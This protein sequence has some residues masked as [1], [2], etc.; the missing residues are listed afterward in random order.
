MVSNQKVEETRR[1]YVQGLILPALER[2]LE[3]KLCLG[4]LRLSSRAL[5]VS[6]KEWL[7]SQA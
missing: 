7:E 4:I 2:N 3:F 6:R 5:K 1:V